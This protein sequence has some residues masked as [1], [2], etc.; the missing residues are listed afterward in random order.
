[1]TKTWTTLVLTRS[2]P[3]QEIALNRPDLLNSVNS[4]MRTELSR[5]FANAQADQTIRC[6]LLTG[7][8]RAFCAGQDLGPLADGQKYDLSQS[9]ENEY[10]PLLR[11]MAAL[12]KPLVCAVNGVA[13]GAEVGLALASDITFAAER[14]RFVL[15]FANIG[16]SPDCGV[17]WSLPRLIGPQHAA[18][19]RYI[20]NER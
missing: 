19:G 16:L 13:A 18:A 4:A 15:S 5:A 10:N 9:L 6:I 2:G 20:C 11:Q 14:A 12:E 3:V 1:M 8:G 7:T 17:S